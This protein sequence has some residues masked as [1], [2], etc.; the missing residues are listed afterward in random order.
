MSALEIASQR[1]VRSLSFRDASFGQ[2]EVLVTA[3]RNMCSG[4]QSRLTS[5]FG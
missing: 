4:R 2:N 3:D 1:E 5:L